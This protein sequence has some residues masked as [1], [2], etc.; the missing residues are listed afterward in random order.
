MLNSYTLALWLAI[1][2]GPPLCGK[3]CACSVPFRIDVSSPE[4][5]AR[6]A[7]GEAYVIAL[8]TVIAV[9]TTARDSVKWDSTS[10]VPRYLVYPTAIRYTLTVERWWKGPRT[11]TVTIADYDVGGPCSRPYEKKQAYLVYAQKDQHLGGPT[12]LMT[13][14]CSRVMLKSQASMD[15]RLLGPGR[16]PNG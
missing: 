16:V 3:S 9:D 13:T 2:A 12:A 4:K 11:S 6:Y 5:M 8:G 1:G 7:G 10:A 14:F 15:Q